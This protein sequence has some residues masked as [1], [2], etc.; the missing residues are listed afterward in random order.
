MVTILLEKIIELLAASFA[1]IKTKLQT[2]YDNIQPPHLPR[3][4]I[5]NPEP[6]NNTHFSE[7]T[8]GKSYVSYSAS[9]NYS[10]GDSPVCNGSTTFDEIT[11]PVIYREGKG[12]GTIY[13]LNKIQHGFY[14][15]L[16]VECEITADGTGYINSRIILAGTD[17]ALD[18]NLMPVN[19]IKEEQLKQMEKK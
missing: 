14:K 1:S 7:F 12:I 2:M 15:K 17:M 19:R 6:L 8:R 4:W 16:F 18:E 10:S 5:L 3:L 9:S 11:Q 13:F